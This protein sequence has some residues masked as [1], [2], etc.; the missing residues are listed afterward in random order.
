MARFLI[1]AA[2][3]INADPIANKR[4]MFK[5]DDIVFISEDGHV[6]GT[7]EQPPKFRHE[8]LPG[9]AADYLHLMNPAA[10]AEDSL[11]G[12]FLAYRDFFMDM[13]EDVFTERNRNA[14]RQR[15][16]KLISGQIIDK[17]RKQG[18]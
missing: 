17:E 4:D 16:Y 11:P 14:S 6:W 10:E 15:R 7:A 13:V 12:D 8:E 3:N 5:G 2:D 18:F 9:P 1:L